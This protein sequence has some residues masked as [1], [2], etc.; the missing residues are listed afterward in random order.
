[1]T[2]MLTPVNCPDGGGVECSSCVHMCESRPC[3][4]TPEE[5]LVLIERGH[6]DRLMLDYWS[7]SFCD[8]GQDDH[9]DCVS[10]DDVMILSPAI[11]GREGKVAPF[12]PE[13]RCTFLTGTGRC[14]L[15]GTCQP[16]EG[17]VADCRT[18][19]TYPL[20]EIVARTWARR[21]AQEVVQ[22]WQAGAL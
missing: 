3:W 4:P 5:A 8:C 7:G 2:A 10:G 13:G 17:R 12:W 20:H 9:S 1:M 19:L 6:G 15:Y 18:D 21:E 14:E 11:V 16:L 22:R